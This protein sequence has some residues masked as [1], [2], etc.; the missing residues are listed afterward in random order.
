MEQYTVCVSLNNIDIH[1]FRLI[2]PVLLCM[3]NET[4]I[5]TT[6]VCMGLA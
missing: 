5:P 6:T 3:D 1:T 4:T 2:V